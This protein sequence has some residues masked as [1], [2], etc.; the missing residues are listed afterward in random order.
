[1]PEENP[2]A[3]PAF[4]VGN[5]E[6]AQTYPGDLK[7]GGIEALVVLVRSAPVSP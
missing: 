5:A 7:G 1:M 6:R 3:F 2:C 4:D